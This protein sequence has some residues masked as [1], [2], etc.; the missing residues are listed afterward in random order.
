MPPFDNIAYKTAY[1]SLGQYSDKGSCESNGGTWYYSNNDSHDSISSTAENQLLTVGQ[2]I[3]G[4]DAEPTLTYD[5]SILEIKYNSDYDD[6]WQTSATTNLLKLTY[7]SEKYATMGVESTGVLEINASRQIILDAPGGGVKIKDD[8]D[9]HFEFDCNNTRMFIFDD[10]DS[11]D[12][13][14]TTVD[15]NGA[16]TLKTNDNDGI[17]G[18]LT[19]DV[20]GDLILDPTSGLTKFYRAGDTDD[21]CTLQVSADGAT[22]IATSDSDGSAGN[23]TLAPNGT[24]KLT[25][26]NGIMN[27]YDSDNS[28]DYADI[29]V[30]SNGELLISTIDAAAAAAYI[31]LTA[32]GFIALEPSAGSYVRIDGSAGFTQATTTYSDDSITSSG[33]TN[34]TDVDFRTTNK[35]YL[36]PSAGTIVNLNLIFPVV[37]G[38]FLLYTRS[39]GSWAV[40]NWISYEYDVTVASGFSGEVVWP[41]GTE[42]TLTAEGYDIF[43]FYWDAGTQR[44]FGQA[45][46]NFT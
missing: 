28:A 27:F 25:P 46:L 20:D 5:G 43:S 36:G 42:P 32:D 1:C 26:S 3:S 31:K 6:N 18:H 23:L 34:D 8:G 24:L 16:T 12:Y 13:F 39:A 38:N 15:A 9:S 40:T 19:L 22:T 2:S 44:C 14:L 29:R 35:R 37:S 11:S 10:T 41:G 17:V 30:G 33:G 45:G 21:L 7:D 4:V